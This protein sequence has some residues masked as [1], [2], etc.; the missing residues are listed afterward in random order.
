MSFKKSP[1]PKTT[2]IE[3]R[4]TPEEKASI[5]AEAKARLLT[6]SS[7]ALRRMLGKQTPVQYEYIAIARLERHVADLK[8]IYRFMGCRPEDEL[9]LK[10]LLVE[11]VVAVQELWAQRGRK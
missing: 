10:P 11:M 9:L 3:I 8:Q 4:V 2:S 6:V 7:F 5:E 1:N